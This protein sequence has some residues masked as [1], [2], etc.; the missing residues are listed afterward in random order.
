M[1]Y[2]CDRQVKN[3]CLKFGVKMQNSRLPQMHVSHPS[4]REKRVRNSQLKEKG[5]KYKHWQNLKKKQRYDKTLFGKD[6]VTFISEMVL[7]AVVA[8]FSTESPVS[9][10]SEKFLL[11]V[12]QSKSVPGPVSEGRNQQWLGCSLNDS[13]AQTLTAPLTAGGRPATKYYFTLSFP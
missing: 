7:L 8:V 9:G 6:L 1:H 12:K 13:T 11:F 10:R 2:S 4:G 5:E 3:P